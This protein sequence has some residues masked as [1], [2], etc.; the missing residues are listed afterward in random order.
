MYNTKFLN[1][2]MF[3]FAHEDDALVIYLH[4][5]NAWTVGNFVYQIDF[6]VMNKSRPDKKLQWISCFTSIIKYKTIMTILY[7]NRD[8]KVWRKKIF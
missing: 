7:K 3:A 2:A 1:P 5:S 8:C 6:V 4:L